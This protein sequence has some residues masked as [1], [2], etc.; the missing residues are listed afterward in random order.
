MFDART[1]LL[2]IFI[3]FFAGCNV[4][5]EDF[6]RPNILVILTDQQSNNTVSWIGNPNVRTPAMDEIASKGI[7]FTESYCTS[8]VCG[9]S[10]SSIIT[11]K[12][13]HETGA[14]WNPTQLRPETPTL[15]DIFA[16]A[17]YN[18]VWAGKWHVKSE[19]PARQKLDSVRGFKVIPFTVPE[20]ENVRLN[21]G[22]FSAGGLWTFGEFTDRPI[23]DAAIDYISN[24]NEQKPFLLAVSLHNPHDINHLVRASKEYDSWPWEKIESLPDLPGNFQIPEEE[25]DA[26]KQKRKMDHYGDELLIAQNYSSSDWRAYLYNYY[27]FIEMVDFQIGRIL[28]A[29]REKGFSENTI[30]IFTSDH[31]DGMASHQWAAKL[32]LYEE[33]SKV[34][35]LLYWEGRIP[36]GI[37][38]RKHLVSGVDLAPTL[39]DY[40]GIEPNLSFSGKSLKPIV[41]D[42]NA[43]VR[44]HLIVELE[45]DNKDTSRHARMIRNSRFKYNVYNTGNDN[46]QLFD[47]WNDPGETKNLAKGKYYSDVKNELKSELKKWAIQTQDNSLTFIPDN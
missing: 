33:A 20:N 31:G 1:Y 4:K 27:R 14:V 36:R 35:F 22:R 18:T 42:P 39:C 44:K 15:G 5:D 19:F 47:L 16:K 46:E 21:L 8:P 38:D 30:V 2:G 37:I 24:Y 43:V 23:A 26:V 32:S 41:E 29:L 45:D 9:P 11:G 12:M 10:R 28:K 3:L 25:P 7:F 13:P 6:L 40:A 34:P 17:G